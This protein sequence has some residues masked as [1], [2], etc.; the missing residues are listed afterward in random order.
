MNEFKKQTYSAQVADYVRGLIL[1]GELAPGEAV[2]EARIAKELSISR[3]PVREA[4]QV[5]IREGLIDAHPQKRKHVKELTS[6]QIKT[7]ILPAA[8]WKQ[9]LWPTR[10][11]YTRRK[12]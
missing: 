5:L 12:I 9:P 3:A 7:A 2:E 4:M 6:K 10:L 11:I 1:S 8:C